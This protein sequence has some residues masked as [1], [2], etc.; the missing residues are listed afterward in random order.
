MQKPYLR[1]YKNIGKFKVFI[2]DGDYIRKNLNGE[3]TNFA[4]HYRF[5]NMV[6]VA[7]FWLDR[8][9][10]HDEYDHFIEHMRKEY[11][12]M[13]KGKSYEIAIHVASELEEK[14]RKPDKDDELYIKLLKKIGK[15]N[16]WLVNGKLVRDKYDVNFTAGG[17]DLVYN[18][19]P[20]HEVWIDNKI[21]VKGRPAVVLH[22]MYERKKMEN[23][24]PYLSAHQGATIKERKFRRNKRVP[25]KIHIVVATIKGMR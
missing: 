16:I 22:E 21:N 1:H 19:I 25:K 2:V 8:T 5:P 23:R 12:L 15:L 14:A 17:H 10:E 6:P 24:I 7:E 13:K 11:E 18:Y 20:D 4:Q 3:F 9:Y